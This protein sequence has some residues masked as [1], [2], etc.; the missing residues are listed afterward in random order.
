MARAIEVIFEDNV[1]KPIKPVEGM[2]EHERMIAI[3]S[4]RSDKKGLR[5]L[6]GTISQDEAREMMTVI[7]QEFGHIE[8]D[9]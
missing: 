5:D 6:A 9:W 8:G 2:N 4:R 1:F 7:D 3:I